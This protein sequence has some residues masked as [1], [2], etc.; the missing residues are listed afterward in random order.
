M[1]INNT[2]QAPGLKRGRPK[3]MVP[4][5]FGS[6]I[7]SLR[8]LLN[9]SLKQAEEKSGVSNAFISMIE[10]GKRGVP[11][12]EIL[13]KLAVAYGISLQDMLSLTK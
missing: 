12:I 2:Q 6:K 4:P 5:L 8:K 7:K 3:R 10:R 11:N 1:L 9:M 13:E